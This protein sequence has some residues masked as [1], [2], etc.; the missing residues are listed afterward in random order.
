[1]RE[2]LRY[3]GRQ[4]KR[5]FGRLAPWFSPLNDALGGLWRHN[6]SRM[7][8]SIAF[9]GAFSL[10]PM[11][12]IMVSLASPVFGKSASEGLIV[13]RLS[14]TLGEGTAEFIQSMLAAIYN[15]GGLTLATVLAIIVLVWASTRIVGAVRGSLN[16]IWGVP[17]HG[18]TGFLGFVLGKIIDVGMVILI[19]LMFL[20][21]MLAST[22]ISALTAYFS[23]LLPLPG[24]LL[25]AIGVVF[26][27]LVA[28][29]FLTVIFRV[30]PN[31]K[32]RFLHILA[33]ASVTAVLFAIGNYVIGRYLGRAT[34][35]SA[36]GAAGS[37]AV[38]MIWMYYS[39]HIVLFGAEVTR[40]YAERAK[41]RNKASAP[42]KRGT[43][44]KGDQEE[45]H[46]A[47]PSAQAPS[48]PPARPNPETGSEDKDATGPI[49]PQSPRGAGHRP[50]TGARTRS[51]PTGT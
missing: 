27:L 12:V 30:L 35:G 39:A 11:L 50:K 21:S 44:T 37:L 31:I 41:R 26:S 14:A 5:L 36:F 1:M 2:A 24:W 17:G 28:I 16:D 45:A 42:R 15:S 48:D 25:E 10:A 4:V 9:F 43:V 29:T 46:D 32:V 38:I 18:G 22:A 3:I 23:D 19:G 34:P 7:S 47:G 51:R 33:G 8:A 6:V 20:A 40:A 13:D 49:D